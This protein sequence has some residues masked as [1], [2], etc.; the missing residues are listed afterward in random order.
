MIPLGQRTCPLGEVARVAGY[1]AKESSGQCGPCMLGLPAIARAL[2]ALANGSGGVDALEAA[3]RAAA[4]VR[5]RGACSHP[6][7]VFRFIVS[8]LDV[9]TG[10]LAAHLFRGTCGRPVRRILPLD[11][12]DSDARLEVD[13]TRCQGHG[14]CAHLVPELIQLDRSGYPEFLDMPVPFW[15]ADAAGQAVAM[16]PALALRITRP[17][18]SAPATSPAA[19]GAGSSRIIG[20]R[21]HDLEDLIVTE[22]WI[23]EIGG[24]REFSGETS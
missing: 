10:D 21:G 17:T 8:A 12:A 1:L 23:A 15:L 2:T 18:R 24:S 22:S 11:A 4:A 19:V 14:L 3:R 5:G 7:G 6:D 16:C 9:F 20:K 13:W